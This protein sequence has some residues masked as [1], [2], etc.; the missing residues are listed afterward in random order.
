MKI[1][2]SQETD[3]LHIELCTGEVGNRQ[4]FDDNTTLGLDA[5]GRLCAIT[6]KHAGDRIDVSSL[7][8]SPA[9][10][11]RRLNLNAEEQAWLDEYRRQLQEQFPGLVEDI[12][13]YGPYSRGISDPDIKMEV[14]V[15]IRE[16]DR[17]KKDE[18]SYLG[19]VID[20]ESFSAAPSILVYT[21]TEWAK[22]KQSDSPI[23][24]RVT[25]EGIRVI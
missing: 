13:I 12:F 11:K 16:G 7:K 17:D 19:Y 2:Y 10:P 21:R 20:T 4:D 22:R 5:E 15:L 9:R 14:L 24:Q 23:Y 1:Q 8:S 25:R 18:V 6:I 3:T